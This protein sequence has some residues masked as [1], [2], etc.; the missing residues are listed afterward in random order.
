[1]LSLTQPFSDEFAGACTVCSTAATANHER[2]DLATN[3]K[4]RNAFISISFSLLRLGREQ[5]LHQ[6]L[7]PTPVGVGSV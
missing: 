7:E 5:R 2:R 4:R 6:W 3:G 1:M